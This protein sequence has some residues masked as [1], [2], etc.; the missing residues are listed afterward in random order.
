MIIHKGLNL[1]VFTSVCAFSQAYAQENQRPLQN[2]FQQAR[3]QTDIE[4]EGMPGFLMRGNVR[5]WT[6]GQVSS[7]LDYGR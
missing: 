4:E 6:K 5:A 7:G 2:L 3:T 1:L